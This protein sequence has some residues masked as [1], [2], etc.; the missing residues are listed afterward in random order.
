MLPAP[1]AVMGLWLLLSAGLAWWVVLTADD[2]RE[3]GG[4]VH[5]LLNWGAASS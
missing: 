5:R 3:A 4:F 1:M 2:R